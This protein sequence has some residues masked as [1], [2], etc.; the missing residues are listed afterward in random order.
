MECLADDII[1]VPVQNRPRCGY[2]GAGMTQE[3]IGEAVNL[4]QSNVHRA[5][6]E[7]PESEKRIIDMLERHEVPTVAEKQDLPELLVW[8]IT[9]KDLMRNDS[10]GRRRRRSGRPWI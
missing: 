9:L 3:E 6:C 10:S 1:V 2:V 8:A 5:L 4:D 7:F